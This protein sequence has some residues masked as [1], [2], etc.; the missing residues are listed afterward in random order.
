MLKYTPVKIL[1]L[2]IALQSSTWS[3]EDNNLKGQ[4]ETS[5]PIQLIH[6]NQSNKLEDLLFEFNFSEK[7][8]SE[9]KELCLVELFKT[10]TF[11][12]K[13]HHFMGVASKTQHK[14][15]AK[16]CVNWAWENLP[17]DGEQRDALDA[18][19][20]FS[21]KTPHEDLAQRYMDYIT[22]TKNNQDKHVVMFAK[23]TNN[24]KHSQQCVSYISNKNKYNTNE[25]EKIIMD[26]HTDTH[27]KDTI[28]YTKQLLISIIGNKYK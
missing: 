19:H 12:N 16:E 18:L 5:Q 1:T 4:N 25:L 27:N 21:A 6:E 23:Y 28:E 13:H 22:D 26:I 2:L 24:T 9:E 10:E 20:N 15:V 11:I 7:G 3:M 17:T 14:N 8:L